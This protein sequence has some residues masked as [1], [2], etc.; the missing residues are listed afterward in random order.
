M[1]FDTQQPKDQHRTL[2]IKSDES[3]NQSA[4]DYTGVVINARLPSLTT[5]CARLADTEDVVI[6]PV[7][8]HSEC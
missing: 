1:A 8:H 4:Y 6:A 3:R 5:K 2:P 7:R